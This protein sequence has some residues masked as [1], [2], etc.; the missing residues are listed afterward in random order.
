MKKEKACTSVPGVFLSAVL[1]VEDV[2]D[3][4]NHAGAQAV[5]PHDR[6]HPSIHQV[7]GPEA[8]G[9]PTIPSGKV[10]TDVEPFTLWILVTNNSSTLSLIIFAYLQKRETETTMLPETIHLPAPA[11]YSLGKA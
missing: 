2:L 6:Q 9:I 7:M 3:V 10:L 4:L 5:L 1:V 11:T 8:V